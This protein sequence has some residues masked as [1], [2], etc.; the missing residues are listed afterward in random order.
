MK[1]QK[2]ISKKQLQKYV[3]ELVTLAKSVTP[4]VNTLVQIPGYE[5]QHAWLE[6]YVP[7]EYDD[8]VQDLV[9]ERANDLF[10]DT[11]YDIGVIV[12]ENSRLPQAETVEA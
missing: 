5:D 9:S 8:Q 6:I 7:E 10:I 1:P 4:E 11:G 2:S 12:H 3:D